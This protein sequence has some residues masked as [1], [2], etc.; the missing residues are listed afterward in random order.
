M[1]MIDILFYWTGFLVWIGIASVIGGI[2]FFAFLHW[3]DRV[4]RPSMENLRFYLFGKSWREQAT[5]YKLWSGKAK[6]H[7]R[8]YT[9]G[10][11]NKHFA[12]CAMKRLVYEARKESRRKAAE[13]AQ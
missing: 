11:G 13:T 6:W 1:F 3:Y 12:R 4:V 10:S 9:R 5:Y 2:L 7:Y 8:Y